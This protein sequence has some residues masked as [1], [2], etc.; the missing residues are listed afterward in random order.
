MK[1]QM[2]TYLRRP[3]VL[4]LLS[5]AIMTT[6][7][8]FALPVG[9]Q[10]DPSTAIKLP[11]MPELKFG[12][13]LDEKGQP[14]VD[15]K[16]DSKPLEAASPKADTKSDAKPSSSPTAEPKAVIISD[17]KAAASAALSNELKT[18]QKTEKKP[19]QAAPE[20]TAPPTAPPMS[21]PASPAPVGSTTAPPVAP[22]VATSKTAAP[23]EPRADAR[24]PMQAAAAAKPRIQATPADANAARLGPSRAQFDR[25]LSKEDLKKYDKTMVRQIQHDLTQIYQRHPDWMRDF[26]MHERPLSD[27][28]LGP[29]TLYWLQRYL[30]NFKVEPVGDFADTL[31]ADIA[32]SAAFSQMHPIENDILISVD[33]ALWNFGQA[34]PLR[35]ENYR[36]RRNGAEAQLLELVRQYLASKSTKPDPK[37]VQ[38]EAETLTSYTYVLTEQ[39]IAKLQ[40]KEQIMLS[41]AKLK[42]E[43]FSDL[44]ELKKAASAS[45]AG[46]EGSFKA[47]WPTIEK[48]VVRQSTYA[49]SDDSLL[50]LSQQGLSAATMQ[51]LEGLKDTKSY[52]KEEFEKAVY[53]AL[54]NASTPKESNTTADVA[55]SDVMTMRIILRESDKLSEFLLTEQS[56]NNIALQLPREVTLLSVPMAIGRLLKEI[57]DVSFPE[58]QLL[59]K[60]AQARIAWGFAGCVADYA[61]YN[62]YVNALRM[63]DIEFKAL[64]TEWLAAANGDAKILQQTTESFATLESLR[65]ERKECSPKEHE[66]LS[67]SLSQLYRDWVYT[68]VSALHEKKLIYQPTSKVQWTGGSC[69]CVLDNLAGTVYGFYPYW[70][71]D[72][73]EQAINF[74][75]LSRIGYYGLSFDEL[76]EIKHV[77]NT[78]STS[79]IVDDRSAE[80]NA[81]LNTARSHNTKVDWVIEKNDWKGTWSTYSASHKAAV[82]DKLAG[83]IERLLSSELNDTFSKLTPYLTFGF[84]AVPTRGDGVTLYFKDYPASADDTIIFNKF[85][86]KLKLRLGA[87]N[88]RLFV[89]LLVSQGEIGRK[90]SIYDYANLLKLSRLGHESVNQENLD[91]RS[92]RDHMN[93]HVLVFLEEPSSSGK[94]ALRKALEDSVHGAERKTLLLSILP[95]LV[96]DNKN[97]GQLQDDLIYFDEFGG[98][99]FWPLNTGLDMPTDMN[100]TDSKNFAHCITLNFEERGSKGQTDSALHKFICQNRW[101]LRIGFNFSIVFLI[102]SIFLYMRSCSVR[103]RVMAYFPVYLA[104][105]GLPPIVLFTLLLLFD[106]E[107][108]AISRGNLPFII[109]LTVLVA[110][111]FGV[112]LYLRGT[113]DVPSRNALKNLVNA[114]GNRDEENKHGTH[115]KARIAAPSGLK[116]PPNSTL[117]NIAR[118]AQN[119]IKRYNKK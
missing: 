33:F 89:N 70:K 103:N 106:P 66:N 7:G 28:V 42:D 101:W 5:L 71:V 34:E 81:F 51:V 52:V 44:P 49:L 40:N 78:T 11:V 47:A 4:A 16:L 105:F 74:S 112:Y 19:E 45:L 9:A 38:A 100:C 116:L 104:G 114:N 109:C 84:A 90:D 65:K 46:F 88:P 95:V 1:I 30:V 59:H 77:N 72:G 102:A 98:V 17:I 110:G 67:L 2:K 86:E 23:P 57:Q 108:A 96:F 118:G 6:L 21:V 53:T 113:R 61:D 56:L 76:G 22:A 55:E 3:V 68:A 73:K 92:I 93:S 117:T 60:A 48:N 35:S 62:K 32:R 85:F 18:E 79:S 41:L 64:R 26:G 27:S 25:L 80:A 99:G 115:P 97:W 82:L 63:T 50:Q 10:N 12:I 13:K 75:V 119:L 83:N 111:A 58:S 24:E 15:V 36:V 107:L 31:A 69:G 29:V 43:D 54:K 8:F 14:K 91:Q 37:P 87:I 39:D 94:K 20:K